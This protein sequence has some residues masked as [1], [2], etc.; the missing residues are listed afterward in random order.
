MLKVLD[1]ADTT[2]AP[3]PP[4]LPVPQIAKA[5]KALIAKGDKAADKAEQYYIAAGRHLSTLKAHKPDDTTWEAY[6][7]EH[8][9]LS[10]QRADELIRIGEGQTSVAEVREKTKQR[11][12]RLRDRQRLSRDS[13]QSGGDDEDDDLDVTS[14]KTVE[15]QIAEPEADE[16][17]DPKSYRLA[18]LLRIDLATKALRGCEWLASQSEDDATPAIRKETARAARAVATAWSALAQTLEK[19]L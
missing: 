13:D 11:N 8:C 12:R 1:R 5:I 18:F 4:P 17:S 6:V 7:K 16:I 19:S 9:G 2:E 3:S 15:D 10:R 14:D